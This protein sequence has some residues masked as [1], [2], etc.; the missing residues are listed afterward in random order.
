MNTNDVSKNWLAYSGQV[1]MGRVFKH[2]SWLWVF[3]RFDGKS[4]PSH[5]PLT[6][7]VRMHLEVILDRENKTW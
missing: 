1:G 4:C 3:S 6:P 2:F 5:L 7:N